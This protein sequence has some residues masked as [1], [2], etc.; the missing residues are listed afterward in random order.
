MVSTKQAESFY[1][2]LIDLF[3]IKDAPFMVGGTYAFACYTGIHRPTKDV[4]FF[5][6]A[7]DYPKLLQICSNAG[8][9]TE[10]LDK[11]WIA[12]VHKSSST[13][14]IIFA[15]RNGLYKVDSS[16]LQR[17]GSGEVL[18]RKV[19][20]M[21]VEDM[22]RSKA[23]IQSRNRFDGADVVHLILRHGKTMDWHYLY[24]T[25]EQDWELLLS[26]LLLFNFVYPSDRQNIPSWLFETLVKKAQEEYTITPPSDRITRG[27]LLSS[28]YNVA[29]EKW[30]YKESESPPAL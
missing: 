16:W 30:G 9:S 21:P 4:D 20:L 26:Y 29:V 19:K 22:L 6:T 10:L 15:E 12:K 5:C 27:L 18:E 2:E 7:D 11:H 25:M 1:A 13:A 8:Y 28:Q 14:D 3:L 24:A 23:Y 17:A